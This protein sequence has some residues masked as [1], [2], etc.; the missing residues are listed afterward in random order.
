MVFSLRDL[1][2]QGIISI[3][4]KGK[5]YLTLHQKS[6]NHQHPQSFVFFLQLPASRNIKQTPT[7]AQ[8]D[9][10]KHL[11]ITIVVVMVSDLYF[12]VYD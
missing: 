5:S 3:T 12:A 10:I 7:C 9:C 11:S 1:Y 4:N 8:L 6:L 2:L